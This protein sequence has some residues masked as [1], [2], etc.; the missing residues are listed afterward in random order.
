MVEMVDSC[1]RVELWWSVDWCAFGGGVCLAGW[2]EVIRGRGRASEPVCAPTSACLV[3]QQEGTAIDSSDVRAAG[4]TG[5]CGVGL[6]LSFDDRARYCPRIHFPM[7]LSAHLFSN[8]PHDPLP[9]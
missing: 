6:A 1:G 2:T 9:I 4:F 5:R 8:P 7:L 3:S